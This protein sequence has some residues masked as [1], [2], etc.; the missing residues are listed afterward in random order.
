MTASA[1]PTR[2]TICMLL[3]VWLELCIT[4][5]DAGRRGGGGGGSRG[6]SSSSSLGSSGGGGGSSS[7]GVGGSIGTGGR[8]FLFFGSGRHAG[9][10]HN[11]TA[12]SNE[13][14]DDDKTDVWS[15]LFWVMIGLC[16]ICGMIYYC[17]RN[18][19]NYRAYRFNSRVSKAKNQVK[20]QGFKSKTTNDNGGNNT[21]NNNSNIGRPPADGSYVA[22]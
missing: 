2:A 16:G 3:F 14:N 5:T 19:S 8:S 17:M 7:K 13:E 21:N 4:L 22:T 18:N 9:R 1:L 6:S 15:I 12:V 20:R 11:S 10:N